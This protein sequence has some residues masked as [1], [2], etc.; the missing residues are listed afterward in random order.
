LKSGFQIFLAATLALGASWLGLVYGSLKQ[1]GGAKETAVLQSSDKWPQQ[2]AGEA[3]LGLQVYR[4]NGCAACHTIQVRQDGVTCEVFLTGAGKNPQAVEQACVDAGM[5]T[6]HRS[7]PPPNLPVSV[8]QNVR[9]EAADAAAD[10]ITAAGGKAE[11]QIRATGADIARGWG[12]RRSV[13]A[14][15]LYDAPVQLGR[16]RA[17]PDLSNI[18]LRAQDTNLQL[19]HLFAPKGVR[20]GSTMPSFRY[21]FEIRKSKNAGAESRD[22]LK[23]PDNFPHELLPPA[24]FEVV[25]TPEARRLAAYLVGLKAGAPLYEAPFTPPTVS[26]P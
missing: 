8:L 5:A 12:V 21:L 25:P 23:I 14:D 16:L 1:L 20:P 22:A 26:K 11:I 18:G 17:G 7:W 3:T 4:A 9:K 24:G 15:Y 2:R 10:K 13:A 19:L 6:E